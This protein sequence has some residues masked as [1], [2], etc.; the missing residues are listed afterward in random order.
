M[1]RFNENPFAEEANINPFAN[2]GGAARGS[3]VDIPLDSA[4][5]LKKKEKE[6][7][8][9]EAD[10]RRRE[11]EVK[12]REEAL[13]GAGVVVEERNWPPFC[14]IIH[15]DIANEIPIHLQRI[16][17]VA[18]T[19]LLGLAGCLLWNI[20][21]TTC[22]WIKG[23]DPGAWFFALIYLFGIPSAYFLWY[24]PLYRAMRTDS[25][26]KFG[27]FFLCYAIHIVFCVLAAASPPFVFRGHSLTGFLNA[28]DLIGWNSIIGIFFFVGAAFFSVESLISIWVIQQVFMYFRGS[29]KAAEMKKQVA[30]ST[31]NAAI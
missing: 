12:R 19:T 31:I 13:A 17:Y 27:W 5:D 18:F 10:L 4:K 9:R 22:V 7:Q 2:T 14:P 16:Q 11:Q 26:L 20:L 23:G 30:R 3:T 25:A 29:G 28:I 1:A 21:A 8:A 15:H 24:R 6:L